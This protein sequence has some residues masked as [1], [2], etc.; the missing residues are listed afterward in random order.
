MFIAF[1]FDIGAFPFIQ[2]LRPHLNTLFDIL[3][4]IKLS[5]PSSSR[6]PRPQINFDESTTINNES[7]I[8]NNECS[9][10]PKQPIGSKS[11][12]YETCPQIY[13]ISQIST[14]S[15]FSQ[16]FHASILSPK[17]HFLKTPH[18]VF[19]HFTEGGRGLAGVCFEGREGSG[20]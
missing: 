6:A 16:K 10:I 8:I 15:R 14:N 9:M 4:S 18:D 11:A 17:Y 20:A 19:W 13:Q 7:T 2:Y 1:V 5:S 3:T 12:K